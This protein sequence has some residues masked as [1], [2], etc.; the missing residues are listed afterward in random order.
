MITCMPLRDGFDHL[1]MRVYICTGRVQAD[2]GAFG[3][4][5]MSR[6][7]KGRN[8]LLPCRSTEARDLHLG[9]RGCPA[10]RRA[11][12]DPMSD[13]LDAAA[14]GAELA[15]ALAEEEEV[16]KPGGNHMM[17]TK[18]IWFHPWSCQRQYSS[19]AEYRK[20]IV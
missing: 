11:S 7:D 16:R 17:S 5:I 3:A 10:G 18:I 19:T 14:V 8:I 2:F 4:R 13:D 20:W 15:T 6:R 9:A 1:G 12:R